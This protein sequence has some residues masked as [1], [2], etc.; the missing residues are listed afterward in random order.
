MR[1]RLLL[2]LAATALVLSGCGSGSDTKKAV[3]PTTR[4]DRALAVLTKADALRISMSTDAL[5][6]G[7]STG[8]LSAKGVGTHAPAFTGTVKISAGGLSVDTQVISVDGKLWA[9]GGL[10][11]SWTTI[12]PSSVNAPDPATLIGSGD[13]GFAGLFKATTA[14]KAGK[15]VRDGDLVLTSLTGT[16]PPAKVAAL[17]PTADPAGSYHVTYRL[18]SADK[19]QSTTISGPVYKGAGDVTYDVVIKPASSTPTITAPKS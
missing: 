10:I 19:L 8:L 18:T 14:L 4:L 15:K 17:L 2:A 7:V 12:K 9:K 16:L 1:N 6:S 13:N 11:P 5:P 3:S